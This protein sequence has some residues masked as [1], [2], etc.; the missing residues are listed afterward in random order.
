M[1]VF[2]D[3]QTKETSSWQ[4]IE[5]GEDG[6]EVPTS[7]APQHNTTTNTTTTIITS[8]DDFLTTREN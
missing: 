3:V 2:S 6:E 4:Q 8:H 1:V 5:E 7:S